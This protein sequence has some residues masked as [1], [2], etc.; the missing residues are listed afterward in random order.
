[1][2]ERSHVAPVLTRS[3]FIGAVGLLM[4]TEAQWQERMVE[5]KFG[6]WDR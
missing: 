2:F 1:M 5:V 4:L 6:R 3:A